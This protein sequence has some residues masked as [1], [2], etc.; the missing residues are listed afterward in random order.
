MKYTHLKKTYLSRC[1]NVSL[2]ASSAVKMTKTK[3]RK[4]HMHR[5]EKGESLDHPNRKYVLHQKQ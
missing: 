5:T 3:Q 2:Q 1:D 4:T